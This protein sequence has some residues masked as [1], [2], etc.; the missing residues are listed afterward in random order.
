[1]EGA[2]SCRQRGKLCVW[3]RK[4]VPTYAAKPQAARA[5]RRRR[6]AILCAANRLR[7]HD[8]FRAVTMESIA[9]TAGVSKATLY[10]W[11]PHKSAVLMEAFLTAT[12]PCCAAPDTGNI[13]DDL[14][15]RLRGLCQAF[16]GPHGVE[17]AGII[18]E[19][20]AD[21]EAADAFRR[22]YLAPRRAEALAALACAQ[23]RGQVRQDVNLETV[24][25]ALYGPLYF[26]LL[27]GHAALTSEFADA[28]AETLLDGILQK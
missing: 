2:F 20:Q 8:G 25:D 13:R 9:A 16:S 27:T 6:Q 18:A 14:R 7:A 3:A 11:W 15:R 5:A 28:L 19:A 17:I 24:V 22:Q 21:P 23:R 26:R 10:R 4:N 1:M 12:G